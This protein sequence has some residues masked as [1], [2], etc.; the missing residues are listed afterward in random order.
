MKPDILT[1]DYIFAY[2]YPACC[3]KKAIVA[4]G[5]SASDGYTFSDMLKSTCTLDSRISTQYYTVSNLNAVG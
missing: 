3:A 4:K 5:T 2:L 1:G